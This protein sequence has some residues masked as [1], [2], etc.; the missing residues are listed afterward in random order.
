MLLTEQDVVIGGGG[1]AGQYWYRSPPV[2]GLGPQLGPAAVQHAG[3]DVLE[4]PVGLGQVIP[5]AVQ[6]DEGLLDN[7]L[8]GRSAAEHRHGEADQANRVGLVQ[9]T[10]GALSGAPRTVQG[11]RGCAGR[12]LYV[13]LHVLQTPGPA[14]SCLAGQVISATG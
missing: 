10:D 11:A 13:Y 6:A 2:P 14:P 7:V 8:G 12:V 5:A 4:R 1:A 9:G 3:A